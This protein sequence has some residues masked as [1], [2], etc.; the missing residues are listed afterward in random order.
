[1]LISA[2][3]SSIVYLV[4]DAVPMDWGTAFALIG[5]T[6]T[7]LGQT[8]II[9]ITKRTG[10]CSLLVFILAFLFVLAFGAG[11]AV[12]G[13]S[14]VNMVKDPSLVTYIRKDDMCIKRKRV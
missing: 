7:L 9:T 5:F 13:L 6:A 2:C 14:V 11:V 1:M 12:I 8:V 3:T 10:R 4:N